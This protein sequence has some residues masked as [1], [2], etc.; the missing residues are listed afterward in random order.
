[1]TV[2]PGSRLR[3]LSEA[4]IH[5]YMHT[6]HNNSVLNM[7]LLQFKGSNS[8]HQSSCSGIIN[9]KRKLILSTIHGRHH[10]LRR[11]PQQQSTPMA[12]PNMGPNRQEFRPPT[13]SRPRY[14][15]KGERSYLH[16]IISQ[17]KAWAT[18]SQQGLPV[19]VAINSRLLDMHD[20]KGLRGLRTQ[21]LAVDP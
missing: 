8:I 6:S 18:K 1:M 21:R 11:R 5:K 14:H 13:G 19:N 9:D 12:P 20:T 16:T 15:Q 7:K 10:A 17:G 2:L 3:I 4:R